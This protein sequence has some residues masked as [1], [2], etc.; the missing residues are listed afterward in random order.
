[1]TDYD[2]R[3][4]LLIESSSISY[5]AFALLVLKLINWR[6]S[7]TLSH[8]KSRRLHCVI[9][10]ATS[11]KQYPDQAIIWLCQFQDL[12]EATGSQSNTSYMNVCISFCIHRASK[13]NKSSKWPA[14]K[15]NKWYNR[16]MIESKDLKP[17]FWVP[18]H[19][20]YSENLGLFSNKMLIVPVF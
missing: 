7:N 5:K 17:S 14:R 4:P 6:L 8:S 2:G 9:I 18:K 13:G 16:R 3:I 20:C 10:D 1:M 12:C 19:N 15:K 11:E